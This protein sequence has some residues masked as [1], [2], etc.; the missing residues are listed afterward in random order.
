MTE[1]ISQLY[2]DDLNVV[3]VV[4]QSQV[5]DGHGGFVIMNK[6]YSIA[7]GQKY[8]SEDEAIRNLC[9]AKHTAEAVSAY[10]T[11]LDSQP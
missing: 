1:Q 6:Q 8:S 3:H 10:N 11:W 2:A 5:D 7:P 4:K 9:Q